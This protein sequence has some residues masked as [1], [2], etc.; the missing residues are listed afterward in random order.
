MR[1][2]GWFAFVVVSAVSALAPVAADALQAQEAGQLIVREKFDP[3]KGIPIEGYVSNLVV[4]R[5]GSGAIALRESQAAPL[6]VTSVLSRGRYRLRTYI[7]TCDGN[8]SLLDSPSNSCSGALR[9]ASERVVKVTIR[10]DATGCRV[11]VVGAS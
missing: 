1:R 9:I 3:G 4:R 5:A 8:C 11:A 7:R 2:R 10:R 6:R